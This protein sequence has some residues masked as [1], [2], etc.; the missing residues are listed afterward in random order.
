MVGIA[1]GGISGL[2]LLHLV[3][4][5]G[6]EAILFERSPSVG[7]VMRSRFVEGP[8]GRVPVDLGPQRMRLGGAF[9][10]LSEELGLASAI[11]T[12]PSRLPFTIYRDGTLHPVPLSVRDA[13]TTRLVSWPGKLR[14]L[15]DLLSAPP[16]PGESVAEALRRKLGPEVYT[17]LAGP[18]IGGLYASEPEEMDA[19]RTL[20][21]AL[22]RAGARRSLLVALRKAARGQTAPVVSFAEGMGALPRAL[23]RRHR[24][25][26][27][28]DTPVL[29]V[30]SRAGRGF[31][32]ASG[33]GEVEVDALAL[34]V[35]AP[36]AAR[37]LRECA[38]DAAAAVGSLRYNPLA[39]VPLIATGNARLAR[40]GS[41]FKMTLDDD[42]LT[43][44]VTS[45]DRLFGRTGLFTAFLGG[46]GRE[47]CLEQPDERLLALARADFARVTGAEAN[48][49]FVHRTAMPAWD[50]SWRF[51]DPVRLPKGIHLCSAFS[52]R[53]GITGRWHDARRVAR[54]LLDGM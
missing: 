12:A 26:I 4:A 23:A 46:M 1:G 53:P 15:G 49:L 36:E 18:I 29:G 37:I 43:R 45:H 31:R 39:L 17:R 40:A 7:G 25:H 2:F 13:V 52:G 51:L 9:A 41:G 24:E 3:R 10:G 11:R 33:A 20:L 32:V 22:R 42:A 30:R 27:R 54:V 6:L 34:C 21:P 47:A 5:A 48:P 35:P 28:L 16:A 44:G 50:R 19:G 8:D 38:P 14:A